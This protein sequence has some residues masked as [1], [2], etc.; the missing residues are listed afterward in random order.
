MSIQQTFPFGK[1]PVRYAIGTL[2]TF[3]LVIPVLAQQQVSAKPQVKHVLLL[4][5]DGMHAIDLELFEKTHPASALATL[6]AHAITYT[7]ART[8]LPSNSWPGLLAIVTGGSPLSTGVIFENSYDRS[9]SPPGSNCSSVGTD[10][11][12]DSHI[13]INPDSADAGGGINP[14]TLPLNPARGCSPVFPHDYI[15]LNN[16]FEVIKQA[17]GRTAWADKH[18]AYDFLNGPSGKGV[19]DLFTPEIRPVTK[20]RDIAKTEAYDDTKVDAILHEIGGKDHSGARQ[21]GVPTLFGMNFQAISMAQ[22]MAGHGYKDANATPSDG[23]MNA[24]AHTDQSIARMIEALK[25]ERLWDSTLVIVTAKHGDVPIDPAR[26]RLADLKL[27]PGI[28]NAIDP[29]LLLS[30]EQDGSIAMLWLRKHERTEEVVDALWAKQKEADIQQILWGESLKLLFPDPAT[31]PRMPDIIIQP[32][33]GTIYAEADDHFIEEHGG[34]TEEDTHVPLMVALPS[35]PEGEM[36]TL[37]RTAQIA[38]T[39][40]EELGLDRASLQAVVKER[41]QPLPGVP[42]QAGSGSARAGLS[43]AA[44]PGLSH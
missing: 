1:R 21:V 3:C 17:G 15:R 26:L 34:F 12:Y 43:S 22:K 41:T 31:D 36:K 32:N 16:I 39:I 10:V 29:K 14:K 42:Q 23:L 13:D 19:D 35:F 24:F 27:I 11:V 6:S 20:A 25:K 2:A 7:N 8:S 33:F 37:V 30:A 38:P 40:L 18:P 4:S 9:L 44:R 28:V 5:L